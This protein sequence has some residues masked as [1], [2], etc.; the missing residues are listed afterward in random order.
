MRAVHAEF[1]KLFTT[2]TGFLLTLVSVVL[3]GLLTVLVSVNVSRTDSASDALQTII[4]I[5]SN[6]GYL[7]SAILG[8]IGIT[9]EYRH[10]TVTPTFLAVPVRSTVV[11][12]KLITYLIWGAV[13]GVLNLI[14][15][16]ALAL[17][18]LSN[19]LVDDVSLSAPGVHTSMWAAIVITAVFG[20]IGVGLG[21]LLRNQVAAIVGL[22]L[23]LF[24]VENV[25]GAISAVQSVYKYLPG[26]LASALTGAVGTPDNIHLLDRTPAAL[27]LVA[28]GLV[29]AAIGAAI[30]VSRDVT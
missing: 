24:I 1:R 9:G 15:G 22:V 11:A 29:F 4:T 20:I 30:T 2:K 3:S 28:Y 16:L 13:L 8:I 23:Y 25:L 21:A 18:L 17:P 5:G 26:A 6:F 7:L 14:V 19:R 12:A 27:L 10:Q